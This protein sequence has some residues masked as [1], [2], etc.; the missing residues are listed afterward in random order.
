MSS[1]SSPPYIGD[2]SDDTALKVINAKDFPEETDPT[3]CVVDKIVPE[4][5]ITSFYGAAGTTKSIL[6][7][8]LLLAAARGDRTWLGLPMGGE[9]KCLF[10]DFE[11]DLEAQARRTRQLVYGVGESELPENFNYLAAAGK[12][13]RE[14]FTH[15]YGFCKDHKIRLIAIDSAGLA[16]TGDAG[17]Y[18]DVVDFFQKTL[19]RFRV[20]IKCTVILIDHQANIQAGESYQSKGAFGS[21]YKGNLSR[22]RVQVQQEEATKGT[23]RITLRHNKANFTD[24]VDPFEVEVRF[25]EDKIELE[26]R[27]KAASGLAQEQT[28]PAWKRAMLALDALGEPMDR[29]ELAAAAGV[30]YG[31]IGNVFSKLRGDGYIKDC[32]TLLSGRKTV[33]LTNE[34]KRFVERFLAEYRDRVITS[35]APYT[36]DDNDEPPDTTDEGAGER[37]PWEGEY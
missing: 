23:R 22:S 26:A 15:A 21:S 12:D 30:T 10:I 1:L 34:G 17:A 27:G 19:D 9:Y 3:P 8:S 25:H 7:L 37:L 36:D 32:E 11:L 5:H 4:H 6:I 2:D 33:E 24:Y 28:L 35:P 14:V 31:T 29:K 20:D 13:P 16:M 18:R